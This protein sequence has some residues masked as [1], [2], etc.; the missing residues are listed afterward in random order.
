MKRS[1]L[2]IAFYSVC[3]LLSFTSFGQSSLS[4][5][6]PTIW[7]NV[8]VKDNWTPP[9][10]PNFKEYL[11]G[12]AFGYG[13]NLNY[14][15]QPKFLVKD[16]HLQLN[17]GVG[18]FNQKFDVRRPFD[19]ASMIYII[20]RTNYYSYYSWQ[21]IG[22]LS[23]SY[24]LKKYTLT[25]NMSYSGLNSFQQEYTPTSGDR[26]LIN[27][28]NIDFSRLLSFSFGMRRF[29]GNKISIGVSVLL[30]YTS[31]RNDKIFRDDPSTFY[32]PK[33]SLGSSLNISYHF[34]EKQ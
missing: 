14:S 6:I 12:S 11:S 24:S 21:W 25:A 15:F 27:K 9:T 22:G 33:F 30:P 26:V 1:T 28:Y 4:V 3:S 7:S 18:Y 10:A 13:V 23:Y 31:Y 8:S 5:S 16:K 34:N 17:I 32:H 29:I 2:I 20:Y 19:Y